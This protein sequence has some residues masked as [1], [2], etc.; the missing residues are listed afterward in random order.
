V[1][2]LLGAW[3]DDCGLLSAFEAIFFVAV[4]A[5]RAFIDIV[6]GSAFLSPVLGRAFFSL[7]FDRGLDLASILFVPS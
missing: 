3:Y 7:T 6:E 1:Y 5:G 2:E 4:G